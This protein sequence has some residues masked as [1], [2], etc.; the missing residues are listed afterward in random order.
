MSMRRPAPAGAAARA[1]LLA[2][3]GAGARRGQ[4]GPALG[5]GRRHRRLVPHPADPRRAA[6]PPGRGRG[7]GGGGRDRGRPRGAGRHAR[8][9]RR[10]VGPAAGAR[11]ADHRARVD[12]RL[13]RGA[14][15]ADRRGQSGWPTAARSSPRAST[16]PA[17]PETLEARFDSLSPTAWT[18]TDIRTT[19][20]DPG[21]PRGPRHRG[22]QPGPAARPTTTP[23]RSTTSTRSPSSRRR[24]RSS[25]GRCSSPACRCC[26]SSPA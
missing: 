11:R 21:P 23:T 5:G 14:V 7:A 24:S 22:R 4:H 10:R 9:R 3:L 26:C 12:P 25:P 16:C 19:A 1:R 2:A 8:H 6:R 13:R 20:A 15:P 17:C 18:Y